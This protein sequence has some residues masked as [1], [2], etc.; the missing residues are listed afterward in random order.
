MSPPMAFHRP[1]PPIVPGTQAAMVPW[2][3]VP[4]MTSVPTRPAQPAVS[5]R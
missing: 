4:S 1:K 3:G 2:F 5:I